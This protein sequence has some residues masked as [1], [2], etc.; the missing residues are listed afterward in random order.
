MLWGLMLARCEDGTDCYR[1]V[2]WLMCDEHEPFLAA[3][4]RL[5]AQVKTVTI[6]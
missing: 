6:V 1:R 3:R 2:G 4:M 5:Q